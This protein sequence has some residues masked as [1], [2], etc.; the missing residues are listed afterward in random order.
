MC[1]APLPCRSWAYLVL[2]L[3]R[4][5]FHEVEILD[6][7]A[8]PFKVRA[9]HLKV[10]LSPIVVNLVSVTLDLRFL[11][12]RYGQTCI[13]IYRF[14]LL[15]WFP[16]GRHFLVTYSSELVLDLIERP[17]SKEQHSLPLRKRS[18]MRRVSGGETIFCELLSVGSDVRGP[19]FMRG[20]TVGRN[21]HYCLKVPSELSLRQEFGYGCESEWF[22][23]AE[24]L[25]LELSVWLFRKNQNPR[26]WVNLHIGTCQVG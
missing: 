22:G 24:S 17:E 9:G 2:W 8:E 11:S 19:P 4:L 16:F 10:D 5:P 25:A 15:Q 23:H 26:L 21:E 18:R 12:K 6:A 20:V 3:A 13:Y 1:R 7:H 14:S